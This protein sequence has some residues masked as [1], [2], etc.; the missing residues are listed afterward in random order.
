MG[1]VDGF[2]II[3]QLGIC[4]IYIEFVAINIKQVMDQYWEPLDISIHMLTFLLSLILMNYIKNL[5]LLAPFS[6]VANL[7]TFV[8]LGFTVKLQNR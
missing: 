3:Y 1:F 8:G 5:M 2:V 4:C 7:I 6:T